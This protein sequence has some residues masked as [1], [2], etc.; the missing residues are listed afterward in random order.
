MPP[1]EAMSFG[2][3]VVCA[4]A[5]SLPE[6]A[7]EAAELVDPTEEESISDGIWRVLSD[8]QYAET[9]VRSGYQQI[10]QFSWDRSAETL[11]HICREV[12]EKT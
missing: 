8:R 4:D 11:R 9:L 7:G 1:L 2:C 5:A 10:K 3:P 12:I 6:V